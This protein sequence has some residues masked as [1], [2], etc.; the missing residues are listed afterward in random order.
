M[1]SRAT[2]SRLKIQGSSRNSP[3]GQIPGVSLTAHA[4]EYG[5]CDVTVI[6]LL[7]AT[8]TLDQSRAK[9]LKDFL[10]SSGTDIQSILC[11]G[12]SEAAKIRWA[13]AIPIWY[14][15]QYVENGM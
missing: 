15:Q 4:L 12:R 8:A 14:L 11:Y 13:E 3:F 9:E 5:A 2:K 10:K 6:V 7:Q 1:N